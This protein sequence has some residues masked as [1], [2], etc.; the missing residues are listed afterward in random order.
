MARML[1]YDTPEEFL[2]A[3]GSGTITE[4]Q[5]VT[6]LTD[7]QEKPQEEQKTSLL[8]L[9]S[10]TSGVQVLGVGDLLIRMA[11]A[12]I[13]FLARKLSATSLAPVA[14]PSISRV[15]LTCATKTSV[16]VWLE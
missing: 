2:T 14:S 7:Q 9:S 11:A 13:P 4:N 12:A 3:L 16:S 15:A 6:R 1:R 8:P 5:V 10:P